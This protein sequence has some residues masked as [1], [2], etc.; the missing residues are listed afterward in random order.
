MNFSFTEEQKM[1][2]NTVRGFVDQGNYATYWRM[3]S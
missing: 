2:R 1:L 3:G